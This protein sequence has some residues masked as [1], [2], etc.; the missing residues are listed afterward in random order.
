MVGSGTDVSGVNCVGWLDDFLFLPS[1]TPHQAVHPVRRSFCNGMLIIRLGCTLNFNY[2]LNSI[3]LQQCSYFFCFFFH[4]FFVCVWLCSTLPYTE[5][6][7]FISI[8]SLLSTFIYAPYECM[9]GTKKVYNRVKRLYITKIDSTHDLTEHLL[10][11]DQNLHFNARRGS[12]FCVAGYV[13]FF[14]GA[15]LYALLCNVQI[16]SLGFVYWA[17]FTTNWVQIFAVCC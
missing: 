17:Y 16:S 13:F 11:W 3:S 7:M 10:R 4:L 8:E 14:V 6:R 5:I 12:F 2:L 15:P 9:V 1:P